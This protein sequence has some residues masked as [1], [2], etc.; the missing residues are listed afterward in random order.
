MSASSFSTEADFADR[1]RSR[2]RARGSA[3]PSG[4]RL[5]CRRSLDNQPQ[6]REKRRTTSIVE[7]GADST[8][9]LEEEQRAA[10]FAGL[11]EDRREGD[12]RANTEVRLERRPVRRRSAS[13]C[14]S[15]MRAS[16]GLSDW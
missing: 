7:V 10:W 14:S 13:S 6:A 15:R 11:A 8:G 2:G 3:G 4:S 12:E 16:V 9:L 5:P 1:L